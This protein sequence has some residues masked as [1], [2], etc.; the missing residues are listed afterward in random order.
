LN[1][2]SLKSNREYQYHRHAKIISRFAISI[3]DKARVDLLSF[4]PMKF[5][6]PMT[7]NNAET[8]A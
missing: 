4:K 7:L 5:K 1:K 3:A 6:H 8:K 2:R